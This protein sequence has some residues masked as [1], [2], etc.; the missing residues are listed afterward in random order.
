[1]RSQLEAGCRPTGLSCTGGLF[2]HY[3]LGLSTANAALFIWSHSCMLNLEILR[4]SLIHQ[5]PGRMG[6]LC[7]A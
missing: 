7:E 2:W 1:M 4:I 3:L 5:A 6:R